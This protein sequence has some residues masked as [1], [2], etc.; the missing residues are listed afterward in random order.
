MIHLASVVNDT[1]FYAKG[2]TLENLELAGLSS[3]ELKQY[4]V[5]GKKP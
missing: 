2:R 4:F 5:S 3:E 1:D